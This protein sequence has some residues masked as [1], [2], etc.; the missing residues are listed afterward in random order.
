MIEPEFI[1]L[2]NYMSVLFR[3]KQGEVVVGRLTDAEI[4]IQLNGDEVTLEME[5]K[6]GRAMTYCNTV[7]NLEK[8]IDGL[9]EK[10]E[11]FY[12]PG[13]EVV[14][15]KTFPVKRFIDWLADTIRGDT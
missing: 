4:Y 8:I 13:G 11:L 5:P 14:S 10:I 15:K 6:V 12:M 9:L 3:L 7:D 2:E 1:R